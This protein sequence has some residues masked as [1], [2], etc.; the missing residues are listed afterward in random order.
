MQPN[1]LRIVVTCYHNDPQWYCT[2]KSWG[3]DKKSVWQEQEPRARDQGLGS[4]ESSCSI[5]CWELKSL[6]T[7]CKICSTTRCNTSDHT[8]PPHT[9]YT[10]HVCR[11]KF[12]R[13]YHLRHHHQEHIAHLHI[14]STC[15]VVTTFILLHKN[16]LNRLN[17]VVFTAEN[18]P[19]QNM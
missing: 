7:I 18:Q 4:K 2:H 10:C 1:I 14:W 15:G 17:I 5:F 12:I 8:R 19:Q 3:K 13:S 11:N 9:V 6:R 16:F